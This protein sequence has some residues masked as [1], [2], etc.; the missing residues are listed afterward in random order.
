MA[1]YRFLFHLHTYKSFDATI[2]YKQLYEAVLQH[3]IT[4]LAITEHNNIDSYA[5]FNEYLRKHGSNVKLLPA[6]EYS[7][8]LGDI[9]ALN[10]DYKIVFSSYI[11]LVDKVKASGGIVILPHPFKRPAYP[12]D[13]IA[14]IDFYELINMRGIGK[15]FDV[16]QFNGIRHI[17]GADAHNKNELPGVVNVIKSDL[18]FFDALYVD[19]IVPEINMPSLRVHR[20]INRVISKARKM[21]K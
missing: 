6:I 11:D 14:R 17:Y 7:T 13:L 3:K 8:E 10:V 16:R 1:E 20:Y 18:G 2:R 9:I 15:S 19:V 5:E 21:F 12:P 4:H